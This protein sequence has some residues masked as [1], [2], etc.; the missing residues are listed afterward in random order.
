MSITYS[1]MDPQPEWLESHWRLW[2]RDTPDAPPRPLR[3]TFPLYV[4][5]SIGWDPIR[6]EVETMIF[7]VKNPNGANSIDWFGLWTSR[8]IADHEATMKEWTCRE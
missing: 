7:H 6:D 2:R 3:P 5:S 8:G 1:L 4:M